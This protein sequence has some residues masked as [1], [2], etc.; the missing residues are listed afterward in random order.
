MIR[1][2]CLLGAALLPACSSPADSAAPSASPWAPDGP[3]QAGTASSQM[4]VEGRTVPVRAWYPTAASASGVSLPTL[5]DNS[6]DR[7]ILQDLFDAAPAGCPTA[8]HT[9]TPGADPAGPAAPLLVFSHCDVCLGVSGATVAATLAS[10]G[11][12]VV[13][14]DHTD[15]TLFDQQRG[16]TPEFR[17]TEDMLALRAADASAALDLALTGDLLPTGLQIDES[18]IGALGHSFGAITTGRVL[19]Q[20]NRVQAAL[21]LG[22]AIDS[23]ILV[24]ADPSTV[25]APVLHLLLEEDNSIGALGNTLIESNVE[26]LAGPAWLAR[27]PDAGHWSVSDLCGVGDFQPGCGDDDRQTTGEPFTYVDPASARA[28][29]GTLAAAFFDATLR[30]DDRAADFLAE[31]T[32]PVTVS[33]EVQ[34]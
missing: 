25:T 26:E 24:G 33:V 15:N 4:T 34:P 3:W 20:D 9:A 16:T 32:L 12:V 18:R 7:S 10:H 13:A 2:L 29:T 11:Y 8:S 21:A 23:G 31:P 17:L 28:A 5:I 22:A 6:D 27:M 30:Q 14:P 19:A 1:T